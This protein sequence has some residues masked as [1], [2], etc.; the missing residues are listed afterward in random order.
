LF[1][2]N[3]F[4]NKEEKYLFL[5]FKWQGQYLQVKKNIKQ[6]I[7]M[8]ELNETEKGVINNY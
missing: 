1:G 3:S 6:T 5:V 2:E 8:Y 4:I 7:E